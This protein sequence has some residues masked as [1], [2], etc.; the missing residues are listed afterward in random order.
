VAAGVAAKLAHA[1]RELRFTTGAKTGRPV[2][3]VHDRD[4]K[5][6][7]TLSPSQVLE[8]ASGGTLEGT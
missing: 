1:G 2:V 7:K 3:E 6:L 8:I 5:V 4:G